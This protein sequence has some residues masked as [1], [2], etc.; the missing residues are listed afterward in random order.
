MANEYIVNK[1][2]ISSV[3]NAIR[4]KTGKTES[5]IFPSQFNEE[6]SKIKTEE[7]IKHAEIP[8]Y[9]KKEVLEVA[10]KVRTVQNKESI[11]FLAMS[12]THYY[13]TQGESG[14]DSYVDANGTQGNIS[15]LHGAMGAK[16]LAYMLDFDFMAHL[17]DITWGHKTTHSELLNSQIDTF[18]GWMRE[19]HANLPCFHVIGNH[20]TGKY[21]HD[22]MINKGNTGVYTESGENLYNK[23]TVVSDSDDTVFGGQQYGGYCYRDFE[24]KR[25]RVFMLNTCETH[26]YNQTENGML[27]SQLLWF[28]NALL[29]LNNKS[30]A[31]DW[32]YIVLSHYPADYSVAMPLSNLLGAY[33]QG[34]SIEIKLEDG[35]KTTKSF[36]GKNGARFIAQFHG[37]VHNFITSKLTSYINKDGETS[38]YVTEGISNKNPVQ[39]DGWRMCIPNGQ[40][41]RENYYTTV[42]NYPDI[43][44][45]EAVNYTKAVDTAEDTSF[46]VNVVN[47]SEKKIYSFCYG[48]GIDR[49]IGYGDT[50]YYVIT[51]N[52]T[53]VTQ[54]NTALSIEAG[55]SYSNILTLNSGCDM[56]T[57]TVTMDGVDITSTAISIVDGKYHITIPE[58]TGNIV[59]TAKA[60]ARPNFINLVPFSIGSDGKD[61]NVD[62][63]GYD[64]DTYINSSGTL[65]A[66]TGFT[67]TGFIPVKAGAKTIRVAGEGIS[68]DAEYTRFGYYDKDFGFVAA[69]PYRLFES[70]AYQGTLKEE[71]STVI[72][73]IM[74]NETVGREGVYLRVSTKGNGANLIVTVDEEITYGGEDIGERTYTVE[75][76]FTNVA[77]DVT[78][79]TLEYGKPFQA[80]LTPNSGYELGEVVVT[81]GGID[82]TASS[83][84][85]GQINVSS[86]IGNIVITATGNRLESAYTNVLPSA[87]D[88][89]G[90]VYNGKGY[91]ANTYISSGTASTKSGYYTSGFIPCTVS[92]TLYFKNVTF[93]NNDNY[94]RIAAYDANKTFVTGAQHS[95]ANDQDH[96]IF[97][98]G[99]DGNIDKIS[100]N[101]SSSYYKKAVY[102]R[103][104]CSYIG[105]DSVV[106]INEPV[107]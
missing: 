36:A 97:T 101:P 61:Y 107:E 74:D 41:N 105:E 49:V 55:E 42:G 63:D 1:D 3:A 44:F 31:T 72:T 60:Q 87:T 85:D 82:I 46:V 83:Y 58:A 102:I 37:H 39:Y 32:Q 19:A 76:I 35:T 21:Y 13:G 59:I 77:S 56:K 30:D 47:P 23:F 48:A 104:C 91:K 94:Q 50:V 68:I 18:F 80:T 14:V 92:D 10:N 29:D 96:A 34:S 54:E 7:I 71:T 15:N 11:V 27:G 89:D 78:Q 84:S 8:D 67:T 33:V 43:N 69:T 62:G 100:F 40:Y 16:T 79:A 17:G 103:F 65:T 25:L 95:T 70:N 4:S 45:G 6:I 88:T 38:K 57:I 51:S 2:D 86:V 28:A 12:D 66:K 75:Q 5:L 73:F 52:L 93:P 99:D 81:M 9:V 22:E 90:T 64:N 98:F 26:V 20:D 24:N 53:N 106:A